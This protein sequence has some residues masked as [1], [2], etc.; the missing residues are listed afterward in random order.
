MNRR[1]DNALFAKCKSC[2]LGLD[3]FFN[4]CSLYLKHLYYALN[5]KVEK[6]CPD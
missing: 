1:S 5:S 2:I 6:L 3:I 4:L